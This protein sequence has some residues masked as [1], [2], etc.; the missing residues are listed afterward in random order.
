MDYD[1][2]YRLTHYGLSQS[3]FYGLLFFIMIGCLLIILVLNMVDN[4]VK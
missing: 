1:E 2:Y 4:V 3:Q